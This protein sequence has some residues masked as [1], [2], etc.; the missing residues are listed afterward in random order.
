MG[1][2]ATEVDCSAFG[3]LCQFLY[4]TPGSPFENLLNGNWTWY[5]SFNYVYITLRPF[6][7]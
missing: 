1:D 7:F 2:K 6:L 5:Q 3:M 4:N